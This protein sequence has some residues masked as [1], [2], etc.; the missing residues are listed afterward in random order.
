MLLGWTK[1]AHPHREVAAA[2]EAFEQSAGE[3]GSPKEQ[4]GEKGDVG[5]IL[6]AGPQ[7]MPALIQALGPAQ[8][9]QGGR[10]L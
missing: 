10:R 4:E 3:E 6:A 1:D 8:H 2:P 7:E 9:G 5:H